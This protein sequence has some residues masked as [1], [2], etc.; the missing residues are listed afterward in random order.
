MIPLK[1]IIIGIFVLVGCIIAFFF[2]SDYLPSSPVDHSLII[3]FS[4]GTTS[5]LS[6]LGISYNDKEVESVTYQVVS[7]NFDY[8]FYTPYFST[9]MG[10][11]QLSSKT[12][13]MWNVPIYQ[14]INYT[15]EDGYYDISLIPDGKILDNNERIM[16]PEPIEFTIHIIDDRTIGIIIN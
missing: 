5:E 2:I 15:V 12:D 13:P 3:H 6:T 9:P 7:E 4:D 16:L 1:T 14:L 8:S 10:N 11:V